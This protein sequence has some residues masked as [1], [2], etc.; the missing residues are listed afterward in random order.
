VSRAFITLVGITPDQDITKT[1]VAL[2]RNGYAV[3]PVAVGGK[4]P[5]CVLSSREAG[6]AGADHPCG[7]S[8]A[9]TDD[10]EARKVFTRLCKNGDRY[11]IGIVAGPSRL[12]VVDADTSESVEA[13][14][15]MWSE[16]EG[17]PS[18]KCHT[19]TVRT[20]GMVND[21]GDW[22][23]KDGGHFYF[24]VPDG[25][26][27][28][29]DV[30]SVMR[31]PGGLDIKWGN[32]FVVAPPS[33]RPEGRYVPT[34][35]VLTAPQFLVDMIGEHL[36][37]ITE[38]RLARSTLT[39]NDDVAAWAVATPWDDLLEPYGWTNTS[40]SDNCGC[41]IW[42]K[43][44]G[45]TTSYKSATAHEA[46]CVRYDN[47]E[48][49]GPLHLWTTDPPV[50]LVDYVTSGSQTI[51]KLQFVAAMEHGSDIGA[52]MDDLGIGSME[53]YAT[54]L[55]ESQEESP[56]NPSPDGRCESQSQSP[57]T[58]ISDYGDDESPDESQPQFWV[59]EDDGLQEKIAAQ[60]KLQYIKERASEYLSHR[61]GLNGPAMVVTTVNLGNATS[62][63]TPSVAARK[64]GVCLLY[65]GRVNTIFGPSEA[66]KSWFTLACVMSVVRA[67]G[68]AV[69][70]DMEDDENGF[71][72]RMILLGATQADVDRVS[73]VRPLGEITAAERVT[74]DTVCKDADIIV[75]DSLDA[76]MAL[77]GQD[78][79]HAVSVRAAGA[80]LK[81]LAMS[82][83]GA[84]LLVDHAS[85]KGDGPAKMQMGSSAK[86]QFIDG[87]TFR[88][89]RLTLWK[90]GSVCRTMVMVGKD[91]HGWA[92][93]NAHF[94]SDVS[95][96]GRM[97]ELRMT[98]TI[99]DDGSW[100]SELELRVPP[101]FAEDTGADEK[102]LRD[103]EA[104]IF[105]HM[106]KHPGDWTPRTEVYRAA[107]DKNGRGLQPEALE[108]LVKDG[109][110]EHRV[111]KVKGREVNEYRF[112]EEGR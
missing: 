4:R 62:A 29:W 23:H 79:N 41:P 63:V 1:A 54:W 36:S 61:R 108:R 15:A 103:T 52:A 58:G 18:L 48:G 21:Q 44:G 25:V 32:S 91:R 13:F 30:K 16:A 55:D 92:K 17:D 60:A 65:R 43:P 101:T 97:V 98:P 31:A 7:A 73:Y 64:D 70:I 27:M 50:E 42:T 3:V 106:R 72:A 8:H 82:S 109:V 94:Q 45:G 90:P 56:V 53:G 87:A 93:S 75:V 74:I 100:V 46:D 85:E 12:I 47:I 9:I 39:A 69:V 99:S 80:W 107:G 19:P 110:I 96:W 88:A 77:Q 49:H 57:S 105:D 38:R 6:Q 14:L 28:A 59:P 95:D 51:T 37:A 35:D 68:R 2:T 102:E 83:N 71:A 24:E 33:V 76:Y 66:G 89:D 67:G 86:K 104:L 10:K 84:V 81:A 34:G 26:D 20:P 5:V 11:N 111:E 112:T 22:V 40:K 78:S